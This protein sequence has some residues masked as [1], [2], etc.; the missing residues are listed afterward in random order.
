MKI[1][2]RG[3]NLESRLNRFN[4]QLILLQGAKVKTFIIKLIGFLCGEV[5]GSEEVFGCPVSLGTVSSLKVEEE[6]HSNNI[7]KFSLKK[8]GGKGKGEAN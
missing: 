7:L 5:G 1:G 6:G 3:L 8:K 2:G 4:G